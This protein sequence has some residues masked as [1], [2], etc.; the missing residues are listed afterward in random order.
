[1]IDQNWCIYEPKIIENCIL[2]LPG[3]GGLGEDLAEIYL[4][5]RLS[6]TL[7]VGITPKNK[8]W[9]PM[10]FGP[11][12]QKRAV[13]GIDVAMEAIEE[14]I[15]TI[16]KKYNINSKKI[17][18][19]GFSA[20]A[21]MAIQLAAHSNKKF[22]AVISHCGAILE[23]YSMPKAQNK[24]PILLTHSWDDVI[25]DWQERYIPMK[26]ALCEKEYDF[27]GVEAPDNGHTFNYFDIVI[28]SNFIAKAFNR[29]WSHPDT[30]VLSNYDAKVSMNSS[31]YIDP[32]DFCEFLN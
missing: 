28:A 24:V 2:A 11:Y 6:K 12:N 19:A 15:S 10:P 23:P 27:Y 13:E 25:F 4:K 20:G 22:A 16:E 17:A 7:I 31:H 21:V 9:Y 32:I 30:K 14:V 3:R 18:L 26:I 29:E 8:E 1:M 5:T